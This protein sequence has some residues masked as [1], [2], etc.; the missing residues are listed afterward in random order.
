MSPERDRYGGARDAPSRYNASAVSVSV[1][2][3]APAFSLPARPGSVEDLSRVIGAEKVVLLFFP[4]AFSSVCTAEMCHLRDE[5]SKWSAL[6]CRIYGI[7]IDSPWTNA[8][9]AEL[10]RVPFPILS[11]FNKD[12]SRTYGVLLDDLMGFKGVATRAAFVVDAGGIVRYAKVNDSPKE[13]V[14]FA[15]IERAVRSC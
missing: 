8:K 15:A 7:S 2:S 4:F 11:D 5:W 1:G 10:E 14:D 13:Q 12:V 3:K 9:F 6:G